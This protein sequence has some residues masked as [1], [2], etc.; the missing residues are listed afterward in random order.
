MKIVEGL[1]D[2]EKRK[3]N[4]NKYLIRVPERESKDCRE[5]EYESLK[6]S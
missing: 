2:T 1:K 6:E 3:R 4:S 5:A